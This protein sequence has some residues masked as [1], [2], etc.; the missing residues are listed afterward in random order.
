MVTMK[1]NAET[2]EELDVPLQHVKNAQ[3]HYASFF[4]E[5]VDGVFP[6]KARAVEKEANSLAQTAVTE[7]G[8]GSVAHKVIK[9]RSVSTFF[10]HYYRTY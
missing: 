1:E 2:L 7:T 9:N 5:A 10:Y 6:T 4:Q 8:M 3:T